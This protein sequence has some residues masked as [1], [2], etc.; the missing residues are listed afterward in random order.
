MPTT[1]ASETYYTLQEV[2]EGLGVHYQ[3][4]RT[5]MKEGTL[6]VSKIGKSYRVSE[7]ELKRILQANG[8]A[9]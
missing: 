8:A 7:A 1:I 6:K 2:A 5:W 9:V 3:T 4:V